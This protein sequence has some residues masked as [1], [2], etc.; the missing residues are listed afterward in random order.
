MDALIEFGR[1]PL[2]RFAVAIALLGISRHAIL[3]VIGFIRLRARVGDKRLAYGAIALNT[4]RRL[5]P[6]K[7]LVSSRWYYTVLSV[8]FHVGL[9]LV[10]IFYLGHIRL[11]R[12]G[13]GFGWPALPG[14]VADV[15]SLITIVSAMLLL[16]ARAWWKES[17][18]ISKAQDWLLPP[19]IAIA[20]LS[21]Y[22]LAHP[23]QNPFDF[24]ITM[25]VHVWVGDLLLLI[26]PFTKIV[27]CT[28]L[29]FS[30][31]V[32]E[33]AWRMVP[34]AGRDAVKTLG[35]EGQAI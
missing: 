25:F 9:I 12:S 30:Q 20:F 2:F 13:L 5:N 28:L 22:L 14:P 33:M 16:A 32:A 31:L 3:S 34:G 15:L 11:W 6:L 7:Y 26:T 23:A 35:K 1:G 24:S 4:L 10:P 19:L 27:H 17:R 29:P 21:G 18:A 8:A